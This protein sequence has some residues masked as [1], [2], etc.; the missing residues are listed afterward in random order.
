MQGLAMKD[1]QKVKSSIFA[2]ELEQIYKA[3]QKKIEWHEQTEPIKEL[4]RC[5]PDHYLTYIYMYNME[6][7]QDVAPLSERSQKSEIEKF[8]E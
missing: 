4:V 8:L 7:M 2:V 3:I 1:E 6:L 5:L